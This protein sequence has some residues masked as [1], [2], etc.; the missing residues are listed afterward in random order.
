MTATVDRPPVDD[1]VHRLEKRNRTLTIAVI[2]LLVLAVGL[3]A[4][5]VYQATTGSDELSA[6]DEVMAMTDDWV[7]A[8]RRHD[9]SVVDLY[10]G[11]GYHLYGDQMYRGEAMA[12]H[13]GG[14][15]G[16]EEVG[17][18]EW[19]ADPTVMVAGEDRW[20]V[21]RP[22]YITGGGANESILSYE[23]IRM[24]DG[25]YKIVHSTWMIDHASVLYVE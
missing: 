5:A 25:S 18:H 11:S 15:E 1:R 13:L 2:V 24:D 3:G 9:G 20:V 7:E 23:I 14:A 6:P 22:M 12:E 16:Q 8:L 17:T 21:A 19:T 4:W 10:V